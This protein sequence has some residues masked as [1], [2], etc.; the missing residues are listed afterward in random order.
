MRAL[1]GTCNNAPPSSAAAP[2]L[3]AGTTRARA[4]G[5]SRVR[6]IRRGHARWRARPRGTLVP[7]SVPPCSDQQEQHQ[8]HDLPHG[9]AYVVRAEE[10]LA[11]APEEHRYPEVVERAVGGVQLHVGDKAALD[12]AEHEEYR[13]L[14]EAPQLPPLPE[15]PAGVDRA[16]APLERGEGRQQH[17]PDL[18]CERCPSC[19]RPVAKKHPERAAPAVA[20]AVAAVGHDLLGGVELDTEVAHAPLHPVG[21]ALHGAQPADR[22]LG[23]RDA[24]REA[25]REGGRVGRLVAE[26]RHDRD[27]RAQLAHV[28]HR[29]DVLER[30]RPD[31]VQHLLALAVRVVLDLLGGDAEQRVE[32]AE[33]GAQQVVR[34]EAHLRHPLPQRVADEQRGEEAVPHLAEGDQHEERDD[35]L[36]EDQQHIK[37][38]GSGCGLPGLHL[39][40]VRPRDALPE[41]GGHGSGTVG[42]I[43]GVPGRL[44]ATGQQLLVAP[45]FLLIGFLLLPLP[46]VACGQLLLCRDGDGGR[47]V[48]S[49]GRARRGPR[50]LLALPRRGRLRPGGLAVR[51]LRRGRP[52]LGPEA[53]QGLPEEDRQPDDGEGQEVD[54]RRERADDDGRDHGE[55]AADDAHA[56]QVHE[57]LPHQLEDEA[58]PQDAEDRAH[59][60]VLERHEVHR[61]VPGHRGVVADAQAGERRPGLRHHREERHLQLAL[62][63]LHLFLP[64]ALQHLGELV[65]RGRRAVEDDLAPP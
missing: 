29:H 26:R 39:L 46:Q 40:A 14:Y 7:S 13:P 17:K 32:G 55:R 41:R 23:D 58:E 27:G 50:L 54:E 30:P 31:E 47:G 2:T 45:L 15:H 49:G 38:H 65:L 20:D 51:G 25:R 48:G 64:V 4:P 42:A 8:E 19:L 37:L 33:A 9:P 12:Q 21:P 28:H 5:R 61:Q 22:V 24:Q 52:G 34:L 43:V 62:V 18:Q 57:E 35:R 60:A 3:G 44:G 16:L 1:A 11:H 10:G 56:P 53:C 6:T 63:A 59:D 36:R